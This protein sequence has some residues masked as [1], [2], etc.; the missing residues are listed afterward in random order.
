MSN[1]VEQTGSK[2]DQAMSSK[3]A[4]RVTFADNLVEPSTS[5]LC[6]EQHPKLCGAQEKIKFDLPRDLDSIQFYCNPKSAIPHHEVYPN[7]KIAVT[8]AGQ[9]GAKTAKFLFSKWSTGQQLHDKV[10]S[11]FKIAADQDLKLAFVNYE[12]IRPTDKELWNFGMR[13]FPAFVAQIP[14]DFQR[15]DLMEI[16]YLGKG[17]N[18]NGDPTQ[19]NRQALSTRR[20]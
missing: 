12:M 16:Q 18:V 6:V 1:Q 9:D 19:V 13:F 15:G 3:V 2:H 14:D 8:A 11:H 4:K 17:P 10:R 5:K 7:I 20:K